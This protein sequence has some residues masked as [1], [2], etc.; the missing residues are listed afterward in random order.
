MRI[1]NKRNNKFMA[2]NDKKII[3]LYTQV[4]KKMVCS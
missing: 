4:E 1:Q 2:V 3:K